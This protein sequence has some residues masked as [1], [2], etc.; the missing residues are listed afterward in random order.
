MY[1][2]VPYYIVSITEIKKKKNIKMSS[3]GESMVSELK[4]VTKQSTMQLS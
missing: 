4:L 2:D 3:R 1:K